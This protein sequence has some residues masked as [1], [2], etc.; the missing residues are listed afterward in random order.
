MSKIKNYIIGIEE[1]VWG[2]EGLETK[3]SESENIEEVFAFVIEKLG[4]KTNFD[5]DIAKDA[6]KDL[7][8]DFWGYY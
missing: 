1:D 5:I 3:V 2:I 6:V 8:F 7:W 4:L